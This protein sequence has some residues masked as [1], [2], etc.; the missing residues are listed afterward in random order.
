MMNSE[1]EHITH[2]NT[3]AR[4]QVLFETGFLWIA[5]AVLELTV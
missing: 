1:P 2:T 4:A 5:V 3:H